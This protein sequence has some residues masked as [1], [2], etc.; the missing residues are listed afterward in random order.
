MKKIL[1]LIISSILVV[2][3]S[4]ALASWGYSAPVGD[5][6]VM[7][8]PLE[9]GQAIFSADV[10]NFWVTEIIDMSVPPWLRAEWAPLGDANID[11]IYGWMVPVRV[12]Y[13]VTN[14]LSVR[15]TAP[16]MSL[17]MKADSGD[18]YDSGAGDLI[19]EA[20]Y[21]VMK[22]SAAMPAILVNMG[23]RLPTGRRY[24]SSFIDYAEFSMGTG[25]NEL[26]FSGILKKKLGPVNGKAVLTY[27]RPDPVVYDDGITL[28]SKEKWIYSFSLVYPTGL[29]DVGGEIWAIN[30]GPELWKDFPGYGNVVFESSSISAMYGSLFAVLQA[31][32][33]LAFRGAMHF[34]LSQ[35]PSWSQSDAGFNMLRG[36]KVSFGAELKTI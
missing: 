7:T 36:G 19:V 5:N 24:K 1:F 2:Y 18:Q 14:D 29:V 8:D 15:L 11:S 20:L 26:L 32:P 34:P 31:S 3:S 9:A 35:Q 13:G 10:E 4:P 28:V 22:E 17:N 30:A 12:G 23:V 27:N 21:Q 16:L 6:A 33:T 25:A